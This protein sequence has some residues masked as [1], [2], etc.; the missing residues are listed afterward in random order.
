MGVSSFFVLRDVC[1]LVLL[2][3]ASVSRKRHVF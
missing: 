3:D 1:P 2:L